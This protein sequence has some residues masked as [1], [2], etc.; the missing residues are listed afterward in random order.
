M[1]LEGS[2]GLGEEQ[3]KPQNQQVERAW[4]SGGGVVSPELRTQT[5]AGPGPVSPVLER[6]MKPAQDCEVH[7]LQTGSPDSRRGPRLQTGPGPTTLGPH[8]SVTGQ[9]KGSAHLFKN[10]VFLEFEW[11]GPSK[12]SQHGDQGLGK[13]HGGLG[14][15]KFS[16]HGWGEVP[17][18]LGVG[19]S[20]RGP[21]GHRLSCSVDVGQGLLIPRLGLGSLWRGWREERLWTPGALYGLL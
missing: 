10:R 17:V 14:G 8:L 19:A 20:Q 2:P 3:G 21:D 4:D 9:V 6:R 5:R 15:H 12:Q 18:A 16:G 11:Q 7:L 1:H 13:G